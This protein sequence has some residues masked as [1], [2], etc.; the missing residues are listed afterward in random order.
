MKEFNGSI[1]FVPLLF[2]MILIATVER[3][4]I[5]FRIDVLHLKY[6]DNASLVLSGHI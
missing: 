3:I 1:T 6:Q 2:R 5:I 4:S